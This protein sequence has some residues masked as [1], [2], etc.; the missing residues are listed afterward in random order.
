MEHQRLCFRCG[1]SVLRIRRVLACPLIALAACTAATSAPAQVSVTASVIRQPNAKTKHE[2][3]PLPP[4]VLWL[5]PL[6]HQTP[7]TAEP[8]HGPYV[9]RQKN[10]T[11]EPHVLVVPVGT[12]VSFPNDDPFFHN[13]FSL[14]NGK[15]F[16]LGLYEKGANREVVFSREGVS[17]IFC[18]IHPQMSAVVIALRTP[19]WARSSGSGALSISDVPPG[20]YEAHLWVEG[21]EP[22][23]LDAWTHRVHLTSGSQNVG[24]LAVDPDTL[25]RGHANK[26]G[27]PY[28]SDPHPY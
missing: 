5:V 23:Q 7:A 4:A 16:D 20:D 2:T 26:F 19:W 13:V 1:V 25:P 6:Q 21:V 22:R 24:S 28:H 10:R 27:E 3:H 9:L 18:N 11:F 14:Y 15:R 17:Y 12:P 8:A